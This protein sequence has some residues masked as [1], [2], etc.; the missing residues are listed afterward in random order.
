MFTRPLAF[1]RPQKLKRWFS[2]LGIP[3]TVKTRSHV[4]TP[5]DVPVTLDVRTS[6][7]LMIG[8]RV[9]ILEPLP[10]MINERD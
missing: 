9:T 2:I 6:H 3:R 10:A 1:P 4:H 8:G 7:V 5:L